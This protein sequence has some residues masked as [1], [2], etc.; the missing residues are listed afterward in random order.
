MPRKRLEA[1]TADKIKEL[2]ALGYSVP[3][4]SAELQV[5][6]STVFRYIRGVIILPEF[7][8]TWLVKRGGSRKRRLAKEAVALEEARQLITKVTSREKLLFLCALYW[9]E[10]SKKDFGLSNTDPELIKVFVEGLQEVFGI[11]KD[12]LRISIRIYEDLN[13]EKC[14]AF[15]SGV[16]GIPVEEFVGV[17]VLVGKKTGKLEYG[18]C[19]VRVLRGEELLKRVKAV[20]AVFCKMLAPIA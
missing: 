1:S 19:R 4:I 8:P 13:K 17:D 14:L 15:W 11:P 9:A 7:L 18:M 2:R 5:A 6:K 10:G 20:N 12:R 3:E 16:V